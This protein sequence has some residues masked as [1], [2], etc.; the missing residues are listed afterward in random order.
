MMYNWQLP[1][2]PNFQF[3]PTLHRD[4]EREFLIHSA[5]NK[6]A[7]EILTSDDQQEAILNILVREALK[8][9]EIEGEMISRVD[10]VSSVKKKLGL[11]THPRIIKDKRSIGIAEAL[12][13]S[14]LT[15]SNALS[16]THLWQWHRAI[17]GHSAYISLGQWRS[18]EEP[19]QI[20]SGSLTREIV[21]FEAPPSSEVPQE[22]QHFI[23]WYNE[24]VKNPLYQN[25]IIRAAV[26]H[27]YFES[28]HPFEDGNGRIGRILAEKSLSQSLGYPILMSLSHSIEKDKKQYYQELKK[29]QRTLD[30]D[31]WIT[32]FGSI[33]LQAQR[34]FYEILHFSVKKTRFLDNIKGLLDEKQTKVLYKMLEEETEFKGGM[35]AAKFMSIARVS[36]ATATRSLAD[37]VEKQVLISNGKGRSTN[38]QVN[39]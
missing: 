28:I 16:E 37:M 19:M 38:Y 36:K 17:L 33:V 23:I 18:H 12:V 24:S 27:L 25:P 11:Q 22:M 10:L 30:I 26:A 21:H 32:Y 2:W 34:H 29:A 14:R 39:L 31:S 9:S 7:E 4:V 20:V 5:K 35:N 6:G 13:D 1:D 3:D 15:Y 8:S